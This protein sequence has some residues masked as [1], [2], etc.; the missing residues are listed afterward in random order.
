M[1]DR[2][3]LDRLAGLPPDDPRVQAA[4]PHVRAQL[5]ALRAFE[6]P[7][8]VPE[9]ARVAEAERVL[10]DVLEREVVGP[11]VAHH[12]RERS[13]TAARPSAT[14]TPARMRPA[15]ALAFAALVV[16]I[17]GAWLVASR[18]RGPATEPVMRGGPTTDE[19][20]T[21]G[22]HPLPD[23]SLRLEWAATPGADAYTVVFLSPELVEVG[24]LT[25]LRDNHLDL[26]RDSLGRG[27]SSGVA[28]L[29]R[30][31]AMRG[32]DEIARSQPQAITL[33]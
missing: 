26:H 10:G 7:D 23:G 19:A 15:L 24:R 2:D 5:R 11:G 21:T 32:A 22:S 18:E 4:P 20:L 8:D 25:A 12:G 3:A 17:G 29:W 31:H 1:S 16:V 13:S 14:R 33:P 28:V 27:L 9:G 6:T 30:V